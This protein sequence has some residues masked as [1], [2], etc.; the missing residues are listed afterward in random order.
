M[1]RLTE[2]VAGVR[3]VEFRPEERDQDVAPVKTVG[4]GGGE[5]AEEGDQLRA[6]QDDAEFSA[7]VVLEIQSPEQP[8][9]NHSGSPGPWAALADA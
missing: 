7:L 8:E 9:P 1:D 2:G 6:P 5:V 4:A 3:V